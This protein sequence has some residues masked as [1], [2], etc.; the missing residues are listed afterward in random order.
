MYQDSVRNKNK[1]N[2]IE[3]IFKTL[4]QKNVPEIK[5]DWETVTLGDI[6]CR[7]LP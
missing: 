4:I 7:Y 1:N 6:L 3:L 5:D 2:E